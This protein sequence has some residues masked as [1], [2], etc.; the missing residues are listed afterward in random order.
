M[1]TFIFVTALCLLPFQSV[2]ADEIVWG[3][4]T[5][6]LETIRPVQVDAF[7]RLVPMPPMTVLVPVA[8]DQP[9]QDRDSLTAT[10]SRSANSQDSRTTPHRVANRTSAASDVNRSLFQQSPEDSRSQRREFTSADR[11]PQQMASTHQSSSV[12]MLRDSRTLQ[13]RV[14]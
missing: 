4:K 8:V 9:S 12:N 1:K 5:Y 3:G 7:G 10:P 13:R 14:Y 6:R 2:M 11:S